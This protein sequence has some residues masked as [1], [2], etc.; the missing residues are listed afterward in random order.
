MPDSTIR[1]SAAVMQPG[2]LLVHMAHYPD[3]RVVSRLA[4][5][6]A[7]F[8]RGDAYHVAV[9]TGPNEVVEMVPPH[10]R[11]S[12]IRTRVA[13]FPGAVRWLRVPDWISLYYSDGLVREGPY[14]RKKAVSKARE[15]IGVDYGFATIGRDWMASSWFRWISHMPADDESVDWLPVCSVAALDSVQAGFGGW[16]LIRHMATACAQPE[17]V[18]RISIFEDG[19]GLV[20]DDSENECL[21]EVR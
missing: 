1:L 15:Y 20:C 9:V 10:G 13:T 18:Y 21:S 8:G 7:E 16:D 11:V 4:T 6:V 12:D 5:A 3:G 17:D 14:D 2:D 19:G